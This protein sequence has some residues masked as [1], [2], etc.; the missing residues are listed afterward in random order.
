MHLLKRNLLAMALFC[1]VFT[2]CSKEDVIENEA[3][4]YEIDLSIVQKN[5]TE[6]SSRVLDLVNIHRKSIGLAPLQS[7]NAY[8]SAYAVEHTEYMI[9]VDKVNH[10]NFGYRNQALQYHG[11]E[12]VG[13]NVAFGYDS[14]EKVVAA[15]LNSPG[16]RDVI[17][18]NYTH[19]GFGFIPD[20]KGRMYFTQ[21]FYRK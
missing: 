6:M 15:W 11:A 1:L 9:D 5:N 2:S 3:A 19:T 7:D 8:A 20:A 4:K 17:E 16:H 18:G 12:S 21:L 13:E 14:P 10:D